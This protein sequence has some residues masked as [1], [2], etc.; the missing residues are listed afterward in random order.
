MKPED[1]HTAL[2]KCLY[3]QD[4]DAAVNLY[5]ENA[6][7]VPTA[8]R[9]PV[10]G[11]EGIKKELEIFLPIAA[12]MKPVHRKIYENG[13]IAL[14][15]LLWSMQSDEGPKEFTALEVLKKADDGKW[16]YLIDNP[17]GV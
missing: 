10:N 4:L 5:H 14:V 8:D 11:H 12:T 9:P 6:T 7:F 2:G 17:Y 1:I 3:K 16:Q 15:K 13:D